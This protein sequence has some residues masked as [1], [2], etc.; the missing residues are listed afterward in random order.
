MI[1]RNIHQFHSL[2]YTFSFTVL[3]FDMNFAI[4][5]QHT[6]LSAPVPCL[7]C[8]QPRYCSEECRSNAWSRYHQYECTGL[9]LL[10]SVGIAHLALRIVLMAGLSRLLK[11]RPQIEKQESFN[12]DYSRVFS[13]ESHLDDL[14]PDDLFQYTVTAVLLGMYLD[15]RTKFFSD[16]LG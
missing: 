7:K 14:E 11:F 12:D 10:H 6:T 15:Q 3:F 8:T 2:D 5:L 16:H 1:S 4:I 9:D 13:L